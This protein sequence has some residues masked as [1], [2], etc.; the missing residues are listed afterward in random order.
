M[1]MPTDPPDEPHERKK[2]V[3]EKGEPILDL[4]TPIHVA[5]CSLVGP[6]FEELQLDDQLR[7]LLPALGK[8]RR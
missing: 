6:Q 2:P 3:I 1:T 4:V 8:R 7:V 5:V